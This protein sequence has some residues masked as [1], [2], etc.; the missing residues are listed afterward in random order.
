[1]RELE[2][3]SG[4]RLVDGD[5][6]QHV[7][8]VLAEE[9][10]HARRRPVLRRGRDVV[11]GLGILLQRA[12]RTAGRDRDAALELGGGRDL[13]G[14]VEH[15]DDALLAHERSR[16]LQISRRLRD[17]RLVAG[18]LAGGLVEHC[19]DRGGPIL[20]KWLAGEDLR[21]E[22]L[23]NGVHRGVRLLQVCLG[24]PEDLFLREVGIERETQLLAE[25]RLAQAEIAGGARQQV[26]LQPFLVALQRGERAGLRRLELLLHRRDLP[27]QWVELL[28]HQADGAFVLLDGR[29]GVDPRR[30]LQICLRRR[31]HPWNALQPPDDGPQPLLRRRE[32]ARN[33]SMDGAAD[34]VLEG[35]PLPTPDGGQLVDLR[36]EAVLEDARVDR[37]FGGKRGE[38]DP[39]QLHQRRARG[40]QVL[41]HPFGAVVVEPRVVAVLAQA[42]GGLRVA[43]EQLLDVL[44]RER[45]EAGR[46]ASNARSTQ[47]SKI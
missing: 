12:G 3:V 13:E 33:Q 36:V 42:R 8:V 31:H 27:G 34:V 2:I 30:H 19:L 23:R 9:R 25:L 22:L 38:I 14:L 47:L 21:P 32:L 20:G 6:P 37:V 15:A 35:I 45:L 29:L 11:E 10:L 7:V 18:V 24:T 43:I 17:H 26:L 39:R 1:M 28:F 40:R 41:P 16:L 4:H 44:L 5:L 46:S